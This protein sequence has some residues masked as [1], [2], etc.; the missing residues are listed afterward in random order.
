MRQ[1]NETNLSLF[2]NRQ[3]NLHSDEASFLHLASILRELTGINL[4][5]TSKNASLVSAR[6]MRILERRKLDD[7]RDYISLLSTRD[8][9]LINEFISALTTNTTEFFREDRHFTA[10]TQLI[11]DY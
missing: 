6:L 9:E 1:V 10:L 8:A 11:S 4:S 3:D 7:Y 5:N 2:S